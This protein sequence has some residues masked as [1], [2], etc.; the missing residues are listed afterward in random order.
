MELKGYIM[1]HG[2]LGIS[3]RLSNYLRD[4]DTQVTLYSMCRV[5]GAVSL[6][7]PDWSGDVRG[8]E[9][10]Y[11]GSSACHQQCREVKTGNLRVVKPRCGSKH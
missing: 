6:L 8:V 7:H 2:Y 3:V 9:R 4:F 1:M 11:G 10:Y 5:F